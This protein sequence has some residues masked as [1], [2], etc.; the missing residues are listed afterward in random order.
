MLE[1]ISEFLEDFDAM[2][3]TD[4]LYVFSSPEDEISN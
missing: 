3:T 2:D 1:Y 4:P